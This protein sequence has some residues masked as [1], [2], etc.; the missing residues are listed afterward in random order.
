MSPCH[1]SP[2]HSDA[3]LHLNIE[4]FPV[5]GFYSNANFSTLTFEH[6]IDVELPRQKVVM[7]VTMAE[8]PGTNG[9]TGVTTRQCEHIV[10][11]RLSDIIC[12]LRGGHWSGH[13]RLEQLLTTVTMIQQ[14]ESRRGRG[15]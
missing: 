12:I 15:S 14:Y 8:R 13:R 4:Q 9:G 2:L 10:T 11:S 7:T 5:C 3:L 6:L 1:M